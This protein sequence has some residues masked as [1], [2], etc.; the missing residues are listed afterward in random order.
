MEGLKTLNF[1][2]LWNL[3]V[4]L[5]KLIN[6]RI[7]EPINH[8]CKLVYF[9]KNKYKTPII[10]SDSQMSRCLHRHHPTPFESFS[11]QKTKLSQKPHVCT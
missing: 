1:W 2:I 11:V 9:F 5:K 4:T 7:I 6:L 10:F 8:F 3:Y